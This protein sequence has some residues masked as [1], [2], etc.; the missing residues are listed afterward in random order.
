MSVK[1][2]ADSGCD[3]TVECAESAGIELVPFHVQFYEEGN[4][5]EYTYDEDISAEQ[6]YLKLESAAEQPRASQPSPREFL[7]AYKKNSSY[8]E[9]ICLTVTSR[10]ANTLDSAK[11]AAALYADERAR[12]GGGHMPVIRAFDTQNCSGGATLLALHAAQMAKDGKNSAEIIAS[13]TKLRSRVMTLFVLDTYHYALKAGR[14]GGIKPRLGEILGIKP[15]FTFADGFARDEDFIKSG[16]RVNQWMV[17]AY[18]KK[19]WEGSTAVIFHALAAE[20]AQELERELKASFADIETLILPV[21]A[22]VGVF[23]GPGC[24][25][26]SF[27]MGEE[28][29][30]ESV[31]SG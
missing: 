6:F 1:I 25:G 7:C 30:K 17:D 4:V 2:I 14:T 29:C 31:A 21:G 15:V 13:L 23:T 10:M 8:D 5:V 9:I 18:R 16:S 11:T 19:A 22:F 3:L 28:L 27:F 12:T 24:L 20:R 26:L